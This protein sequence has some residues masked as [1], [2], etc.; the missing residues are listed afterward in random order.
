MSWSE[1]TPAPAALP[2]PTPP[3]TMKRRRTLRPRQTITDQAQV[4]QAAV[5]CQLN[6]GNAVVSCFPTAETVV[7]QHQWASFVC[8][9]AGY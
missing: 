8:E 1:L 6:S 5:D 7:P 9:C 3:P 4:N 2:A